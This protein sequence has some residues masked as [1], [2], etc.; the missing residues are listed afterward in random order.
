MYAQF[1]ST[2]DNTGRFVIPKKILKE[3]GWDGITK[4]N[5]TMEESR[6][7]ITNV[8]TNV[9]EVCNNSFQSNYTY[10][11]YCGVRLCEKE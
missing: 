8:D 3:L 7:V 4:V 11:P 6:V 1:T 2:I 10:C 9:C 5:V